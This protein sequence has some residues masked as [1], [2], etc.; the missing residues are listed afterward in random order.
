MVAISWRAGLCEIG[1]A[2]GRLAGAGYVLEGWNGQ[3][4]LYWLDSNGWWFRDLGGGVWERDEWIGVDTGFEIEISLF[5]SIWAW[6]WPRD[7]SG[8]LEDAL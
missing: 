1:G 5:V 8:F 7:K 6:A 2:S 4:S 3:Y